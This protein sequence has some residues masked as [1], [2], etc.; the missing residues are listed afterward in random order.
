MH[1]LGSVW[2]LGL[3][4]ISCQLKH[5]LILPT[6]HSGTWWQG[7]SAKS[8]GSCCVSN[9]LSWTVKA[10]DHILQGVDN[11]KSQ[12]ICVRRPLWTCVCRHLP[13]CGVP[14]S[15]MSR[16]E[17]TLATVR[18]ECV[19]WAPQ[20]R[21]SRFHINSGCRRELQPNQ[22]GL[23]CMSFAPSNVTGGRARTAYL[24]KGTINVH[25]CEAASAGGR[26]WRSMTSFTGR[27]RF[28]CLCIRVWGVFK[29]LCSFCTYSLGGLRSSG[30]VSK[31]TL[32]SSHWEM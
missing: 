17:P 7:I 31:N 26:I 12:H 24:L 16:L 8:A 28:V 3:N 22:K 19:E 15:L 21:L 23:H 14:C 2:F 30:L 25:S 20:S 29:S 11:L 27:M 32:T 6:P 1:H 13:A 9:A 4:P 10:A 5:P 18:Q